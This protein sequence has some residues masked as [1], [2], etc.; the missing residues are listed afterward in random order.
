MSSQQGVNEDSDEAVQVG[1]GAGSERELSLFQYGSVERGNEGMG[2]G[3][4]QNHMA[5]M[6]LPQPQPTNMNHQL[7]LL[8]PQ[9]LLAPPPHMNEAARRPWPNCLPHHQ[10][11]TP[12][13]RSQEIQFQGLGG[14]SPY[15]IPNTHQQRHQG[16]V[17]GGYNNN[18]DHRMRMTTLQDNALPYA[19]HQLQH[20]PNLLPSRTTNLV[21]DPMYEQMGL[22]VDPHL[23]MFLAKRNQGLSLSLSYTHIYTPLPHY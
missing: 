12:M 3:G 15:H 21:Y 1:A 13:G 8:Q 4:D 22:P 23:R 9:Q 11:T 17:A 18:I 20:P 16:V 14:P 6:P 2:L 19:A 10:L 7:H 5:G